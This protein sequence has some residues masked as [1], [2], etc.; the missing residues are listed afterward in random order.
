MEINTDLQA[1]EIEINHRCNRRCSY[2]PNSVAER[3]TKGTMS[4]DLYTRILEQLVEMSFSGRISFDFYNE[5]LLHPKLE[6]LVGLTKKRLPSVKMHLYSN[7]TLLTVLKFRALLDAG[8]HSFVI[9]RHEMDEERSFTFEKTLNELTADELQS[10]IYRKHSEIRLFN[11]GG[12]LPH[13]G[14][15]TLALSPCFIPSHLLT[16]LVDGRVLGCFE[17]FKE[18]LIMGDIKSEKLIDI[19]SNEKYTKLRRSLMRGLR[20]QHSPCRSCNRTQVLP[21]FHH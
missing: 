3:K 15:A 14:T 21:P 7:G 12:S 8:I 13:L 1:V 9:T 20:H 6:Q 4:L 18:E 19:W 11:R 5:P 10:V 2:C 17:D 16:I